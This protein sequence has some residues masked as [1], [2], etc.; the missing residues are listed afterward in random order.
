M[1]YL[2]NGDLGICL[3]GKVESGFTL[4]GP[5]L[6]VVFDDTVMYD[7]DTLVADMRMGIFF[8]GLTVG[9]LL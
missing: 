2:V 9:C 6:T 8:T 1:L 5:Q 4:C 7:Y 3:R